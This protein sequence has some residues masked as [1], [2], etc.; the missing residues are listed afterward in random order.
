MRHLAS[1]YYGSVAKYGAEIVSENRKGVMPKKEKKSKSKSGIGV[2]LNVTRPRASDK[3]SVQAWVAEE[4]EALYAA[5]AA[6]SSSLHPGQVFASNTRGVTTPFNRTIV[7]TINQGVGHAS[8]QQ[9]LQSTFSD[10]PV[11]KSCAKNPCALS[12]MFM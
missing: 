1:A 12:S 8:S 6:P 9:V 7:P 3:K 5:A 2:T 4:H 10:Q 11:T